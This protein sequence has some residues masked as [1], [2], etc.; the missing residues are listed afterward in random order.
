MTANDTKI[1]LIQ[2]RT[3]LSRKKIKNRVNNR[4]YEP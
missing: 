3:L 1:Q 4:I 2:K